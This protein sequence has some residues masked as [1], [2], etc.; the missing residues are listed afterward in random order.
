MASFRI[1]NQV[2]C[3]DLWD[4]YQHL[5]PRARVNL[6]RMAYDFYRKTKLP[7]PIIDVYLMGSIASYNW[8]PVSDVD[9]HIMVD[10]NKLQM[11]PETA[12]KT[13]KTNGAYW[14]EQHWVTIKGHK[15]EMNLQNVNKAK[16]HVMGIYSLVKDQWI[17]KPSSQPPQIDKN[18]VQVQYKAM[19]SYID[20]ALNSG[21]RETMKS[22]KKYLD[23]YRQ[24]GLDTSG[25]LSYENIV[26]KILRSKGIIK[27]LKDTIT[28][29]YDKEMSV[30]EVT[31]Q[32]IKSHHPHPSMP[33]TKEGTPDFSK[34]TLDNIKALRDKASRAWRW[35]IDNNR[36]EAKKAIEDY[37]LMDVEIKHRLKYINR[38]IN[39]NEDN[40]Y[41]ATEDFFEREM[42]EMMELADLLKQSK[43]RG[44]VPW[45]KVPASLLKKVWLQF[46]KYHRINENDLD[47]IAD[48]I[49]TNIARLS[50]STKMMGHSPH[51]VRPDLA[52]MGIE[53]TDE[54]WDK[55]MS[56][57]F[58][59]KQGGWLLSDYGLR[60]LEKI[61][62]Q[63]FNA[64][65]P[66]EKLYA[67]DKALN[68]IHQRGDLAD[69][70]VDGGTSTLIAVANQGGYVNPGEP[71]DVNRSFWNEGYGA[72][73][74]EDDRLHIKGNRWQIRSKDAPKTPKISDEVKKLN[75]EIITE[76]L[77]KLFNG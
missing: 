63:I 39:E 1:Y 28:S 57:Y 46:G 35:A 52:D 48:Q 41:N 31:Q 72:G 65:T 56:N 21:N 19:K 44:H 23:A 54:E 2:L 7:A 30:A 66:E 12:I 29:V 37:E 42:H 34:M 17:R 25:E 58:T 32:D 13:I 6:L 38:P 75:D 47:K 20:S 24:Y 3:P 40:D 36:D 5:D 50:A 18:V 76:V 67:V 60:P 9:V 11:P 77:A 53:F 61:Y 70:F 74:P 8:T 73:R 68:V 10:Y 69:M 64:D 49:L 55:W 27:R 26:F 16:P 33:Y 15:V 22:S 43:G 14:N 59:N 51:D 71:G 4:E 45:K 62:V